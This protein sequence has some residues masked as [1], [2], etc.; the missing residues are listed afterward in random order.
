MCSLN[1][2]T[3]ET[4]L[5]ISW[6]VRLSLF[7]SR[8]L[9][10]SVSSLHGFCLPPSP[11]S[12][13]TWD[14][15]RRGVNNPMYLAI[16]NIIALRRSARISHPCSQRPSIFDVLEHFLRPLASVSLKSCWIKPFILNASLHTTK[17]KLEQKLDFSG[18]E[19]SPEPSR[20]VVYH[21]LLVIWYQ[22]LASLPWILSS[23]L[24]VPPSPVLL[25][26]QDS[27]IGHTL[28]ERWWTDMW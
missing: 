21:I 25:F 3:S 26:P 4:R 14:S 12:S 23:Y 27:S 18:Q 6:C 15:F 10:A 16:S 5:Q 11:G 24:R 17:V 19:Q 22:F 28:Q 9:A 20:F 2:G 13:F 8:Y 1:A 7:V